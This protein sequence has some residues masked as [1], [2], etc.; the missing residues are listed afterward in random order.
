MLTKQLTR[1][2]VELLRGWP[3]RLTGG[4]EGPAKAWRSSN[5]ASPPVVLQSSGGA[6]WVGLAAL[7]AFGTVL[8]FFPLRDLLSGRL[9]VGVALAGAAGLAVAIGLHLWVVVRVCRP[10]VV[11]RRMRWVAMTESVI[12]LLLLLTMNEQDWIAVPLFGLSDL[13]LVTVGRVRLLSVGSMVAVYVLLCARTLDGADLPGNLLTFVVATAFCYGIAGLVRAARELDAT[14]AELA[15]AA[16]GVERLRV[17]RDLHDTLGHSITVALVKLELA[18]RLGKHQASRGMAETVEAK[19]LLRSAMQELQA[20]VVGM[21]DLSLRREVDSAASVLESAGIAV[22]ASV[23]GDEFT[24]EVADAACWVIREATTNV[25][26]HSS[27][28]RCRITLNCR[29]GMLELQIANDGVAAPNDS[30]LHPGSKGIVGMR[31]RMAAVGGSLSS[32]LDAAGDFVL[33]MS[34]PQPSG[35]AS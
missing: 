14:R 15:H 10:V 26:R 5:L 11:D 8:L 12:F 17:A 13:L 3:A 21:R 9:P 4:D 24:G 18:E 32:G 7:V 19:D 22:T 23:V 1:K 27:A 31:E 29:D 33:R 20:V 25:L 28:T 30:T 35:K 34:A 6:V 2:G 16:I